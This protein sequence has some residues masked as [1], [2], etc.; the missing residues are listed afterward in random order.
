[1][2]FTYLA[3]LEYNVNSEDDVLQVVAELAECGIKHIRNKVSETGDFDFLSVVEELRKE[4]LIEEPI[5]SG[6]LNLKGLT[7]EK[8][9]QSNEAWNLEFKSSMI[10]DYTEL[11]KN[12]K[13]GFPIAKTI[14]AFANTEGGTIVIGVNDKKEII[15]LEKDINLASSERHDLDGYEQYFTIA[16]MN[17]YFSKDKGTLA[18]M[19]FEKPDGKAVA[20]IEVEKAPKPGLWV[21]YKDN[22]GESKED[23]YIRPQNNNVLLNSRE[24]SNY[25]NDHWS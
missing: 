5:E 8:L 22:N 15:G 4:V 20:I 2:A 18:R 24:T 23:Y 21:K 19:R 7:V 6:H 11:K 13:L 16:F 3:K 25:I 1:M 12:E 10:W 14:C 9:L 17:K